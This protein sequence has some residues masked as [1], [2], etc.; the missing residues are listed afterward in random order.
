MP[1]N[2]RE[3]DDQANGDHK[4]GQRGHRE[5]RHGQEV[6]HRSVFAKARIGASATPRMVP[7]V[8]ETATRNAELAMRGPTNCQHA[9]TARQRHAGMTPKH[10][11]NPSPG[12]REETLIEVKLLV[13]AWSRSGVAWVPSMAVAALPGRTCVAQKTMN[14]TI[15]SVMPRRR[16]AGAASPQW[17]LLARTVPSDRDSGSGGT[18]VS[19]LNYAH[20]V[21]SVLRTPSPFSRARAT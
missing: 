8:P 19:A 17:D 13:H 21:H 2:R 9:L 16:H 5:R 4:L 10:R 15:T 3:N 6:I 11:R 7:I 12:L 18:T 1:K 14:E 20:S